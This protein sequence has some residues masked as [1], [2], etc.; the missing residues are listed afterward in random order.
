MDDEG[1]EEEGE[2]GEVDRGVILGGE[3]MVEL[4]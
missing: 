4:L 1:G 3:G 2:E